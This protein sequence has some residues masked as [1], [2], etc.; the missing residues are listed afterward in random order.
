MQL[1]LTTQQKADQ[2]IFR[3]FVDE[4]IAPNA[5]QHE[6]AEALPETLINTLAQA[7]YLVA[8]LPPEAG[9]LGMD[10]LTY[11]LLTEEVGRGCGSVRNLIAV[12]GMVAHAI[13]K[14]GTLAQ[15]GKWVAKIGQGETVAAFALTEPNIGS[16]AGNATTSATQVGNQYI[17]NGHKK[18]ISF[19][20]RA[21]LFLI[22][23]QCEGRMGAFLVERNTPGFTTAPI[24]G[25]LGLRASM[26]GEIQLDNCA[27][28]QENLV[29]KIGFG[30][31]FVATT[32]LDYGR[33]STACGCVGIAQGCLEASQ[34]YTHERTQ[35]G[36]PIKSHQLV[37]Q[38]LTNMIVNV[39]AARLLCYQAGYLRDKKSPDAIRSTMI[40]KYFAST[41]ATTIANDA[42]QL[43]GANGCGPDYPVQRYLRD[44]KIQEIIEGTSQI[45]QIKIAELTPLLRRKG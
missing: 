35:F 4:T 38:M 33:Y 27:I 40:A 13:L 14:W 36:V 15:K 26:I 28:P 31:D 5:A 44:A 7:R 23:A 10:M 45:Q 6:Q 37:Q 18:W 41:A 29:G 21:D 30:L 42:V 16:D 32:S 3:A 1:E 9:G 8:T 2:A 11:G 39:G 22:F 17:L 19:A 12:Q 34:Q 20:Q 24:S 25:L 43:H